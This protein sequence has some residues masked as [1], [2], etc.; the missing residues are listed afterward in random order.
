MIEAIFVI[1]ILIIAFAGAIVLHGAYAAKM[2]ANREARLAAWSRALHGC[3]SESGSE[4]LYD[5]KDT[6]GLEDVSEDSPPGF[7]KVG[8]T[9]STQTAS[10]IKA[11]AVIGAANLSVSSSQELA[12][13]DRMKEEES[14]DIFGKIGD[15]L[16]ILKQAF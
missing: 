4:E 14:D 11:P 13:N 12:C 16:G 5:S 10:D 7:L 2:R 3:E 8:H 9:S 15:A 1:S 6:D